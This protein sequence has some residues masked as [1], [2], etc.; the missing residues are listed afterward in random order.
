MNRCVYPSALFPL[1]GDIS[2][3]AGQVLV[4]VKGL[5]TIPVLATT[6]TD[7][8]VLTYVAVNG[9]WEPSSVSGSP[10]LDGGTANTNYGG[11]TAINGG[12]A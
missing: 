7:Q 6:P 8:Q 9:D 10:N 5:Q 4:T 11:T 12:G 2:A 1:R 3:E